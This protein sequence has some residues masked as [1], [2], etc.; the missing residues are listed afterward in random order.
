MS[1]SHVHFLLGFL[2][3]M[4]LSS[5]TRT[6]MHTIRQNKIGRKITTNIWNIQG[7]NGKKS[8]IFE[9][10]VGNTC[11]LHN[12]AN[13]NSEGTHPGGEGA[14]RSYCKYLYSFRAWFFLVFLVFFT[15]GV[16]PAEC[17]VCC[18]R[19]ILSG[20]WY[21]LWL[22]G[23]FRLLN[24]NFIPVNVV[25]CA[26]CYSADIFFI[27]ICVCHFFVVILHRKMIPLALTALKSK[28]ILTSITII[29]R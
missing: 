25:C 13:V 11:Y 8:N 20:M 15:R 16:A 18:L 3:I 26:E 4:V 12:C 29:S 7:F 19:R 10:L 9:F 21:H 28:D 2:V 17:S 5:H 14:C 23:E 22:L 1:E 24:R 27:F 6:C